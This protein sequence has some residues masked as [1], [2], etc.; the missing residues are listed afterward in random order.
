Q[1]A[2]SPRDIGVA[3][4]S[5]TFT[6]QIGGTLGVAV[7]LSILFS[8]VPDRIQTAFAKVAPTAEF[9]AA[10]KN[11]QS[12]TGNTQANT[13]FIHS[14]QQAQTGGGGGGSLNPLSDSSFIQQLDP[15][16]AKPFLIGFSQA[17]DLVFLIGSGVMVLAFIVVWFLPHVELRSGS[18][19]ESRGKS[20]A[21]DAADALLASEAEAATPNLSH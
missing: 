6:R 21:A 1:N 12:P 4:S 17:M 20:D 8:V 14:L 9:Q 15:R 5:A 18:A 7:F 2:V 13:E 3:T 10:L 16:L 11:P 19:Y